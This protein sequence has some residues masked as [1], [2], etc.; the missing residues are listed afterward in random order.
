MKS[1][2]R[3]NFVESLTGRW[4]LLKIKRLAI[5]AGKKDVTVKFSGLFGPYSGF[6]TIKDELS[7]DDVQK[8]WR[9]NIVA[10]FRRHF[11]SVSLNVTGFKRIKKNRMIINSTMT[12]TLKKPYPWWTP[13]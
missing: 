1:W 6:R 2:I 12:M 5:S 3:I 7:G 10:K 4:Q 9:R 13:K 8:A 11:G